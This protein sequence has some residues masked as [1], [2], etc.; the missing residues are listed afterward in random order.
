M[1]YKLYGNDTCRVQFLESGF[2]QLLAS[3]EVRDV[4]LVAANAIAAD[5]GEGFEV[6]PFRANQRDGRIMA[7]VEADTP[8]A[9]RAEATDKVLSAAAFRRREV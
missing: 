9:R 5:A 7:K 6:K 3:Q 2:R 8:K 1:S 4:V